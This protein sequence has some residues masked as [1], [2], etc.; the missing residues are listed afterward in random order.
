M[1]VEKPSGLQKNIEVKD[2][3]LM[4]AGITKLSPRVTNA[5]NLPLLPPS[6]PQFQTILKDIVEGVRYIF[7][8]SNRFTFTITGPTCMAFETAVCNIL[9]PDDKIMVAIHGVSL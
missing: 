3:L 1:S 6:D 4:T 9:E 5:M 2:K 7:Q 8:T